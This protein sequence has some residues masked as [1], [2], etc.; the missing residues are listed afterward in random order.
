[1]LI[2]TPFDTTFLK[3]PAADPHAVLY[4]YHAHW[5][6]SDPDG[7]IVGFVV[8]V[9]DTNGP[10]SIAQFLD[11]RAFT[12]RTDSIFSFRVTSNSQRYP[13][14]IWVSALDD[15]G[16]AD[17]SPAHVIVNAEDR[18]LPEPEIIEAYALTPGNVQIDLTDS[19]RSRSHARGTR[20]LWEARFIPLEAA[21]RNPASGEGAGVQV[22]DR[23]EFRRH[24]RH[25]R[26]VRP[27]PAGAGPE[28]VPPARGR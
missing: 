17:F 13:H 2:A 1:V 26:L 4:R 10:P 8:V 27:G 21:G 25:R 14:T 18:F 24:H 15:K 19:E 5:Y 7:K 12:T 9:T 22:P 20:S 23:D 6:G 16:K 11:P 3:T 28:R